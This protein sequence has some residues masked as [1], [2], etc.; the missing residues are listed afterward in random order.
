MLQSCQLLLFYWGL[1]YLLIHLKSQLLGSGDYMAVLFSFFKNVSIFYGWRRKLEAWKLWR[2]IKKEAKNTV[3]GGRKNWVFNDLT[4][5]CIYL[6][7]L[8][9]VYESQILNAQKVRHWTGRLV[10]NS[11]KYT[12]SKQ[13]RCI[14]ERTSQT[15]LLISRVSL[16]VRLVLCA[17]SGL[18]K[19]D[20]NILIYKG[21]PPNERSGCSG[22]VIPAAIYIALAIADAARGSLFHSFYWLWR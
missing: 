17:D 22:S 1:R 10:L 12:E 20:R 4:T 15:I 3:G 5:Y 18:L 9:G 2:Q 21:W 11:P 6:T 7:L 14:L 19:M 13:I 16:T 8:E